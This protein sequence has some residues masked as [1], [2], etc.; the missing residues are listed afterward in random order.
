MNLIQAASLYMGKRETQGKN[1]S[2]VIDEL[3]K[4]AGVPMGSPYC[5]VSCSRWIFEC[6]G[7]APK[8]AGSKAFRDW[9]AQKGL[10]SW[11]AQSLL[12]WKG[13]FGGWTNPDGHGHVFL[14]EKRYTSFFGL[15]KK[16]VAIGTLEGNSN[17]AGSRDGEGFCRNKRK[18]NSK[19]F[20]FCDASALPGGAYWE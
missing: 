16:V 6:G 4:W 11:D 9:F 13:A 15:G 3:N 10:L 18:V 19:N 12:G 20:W 1:R 8:T 7:K 17:S 5:A 14:I 2:P